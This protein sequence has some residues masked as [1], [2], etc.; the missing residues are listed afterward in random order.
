M[1]TSWLKSDRICLAMGDAVARNL[2][3]ETQQDHELFFKCWKKYLGKMAR[4]VNYHLSPT[5]WILL[6]ETKSKEE[7]IDAYHELRSQSKK[8]KKNTTLQDVSRILS[9]HFR[10]FLSQYVRRCNARLERKGCMVLKRFH[11]YVLKEDID[12]TYFFELIRGQKRKQAQT[13]EKY[14]ADLAAYDVEN[15]MDRDSIWK[16]GSRMYAGLE[17]GFRRRFG[18]R[19]I[20]PTSYVLRKYFNESKILKNPRASP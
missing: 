5:G 2:M 20:K 4:L 3:F 13:R 7:I 1:K 15:E 8:A 14:Q 19:L 18:L 10:I 6:F 16:V 9:E 12:Y 11:K 17:K